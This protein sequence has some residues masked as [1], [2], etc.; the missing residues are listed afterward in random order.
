MKILITGANGQLGRELVDIFKQNYN[1]Y[2]IIPF[3][4]KDL[5]IINYDEVNK[6]LIEIKPNIVINCAAYNKVDDCEENIDYAFK[7]NSI[8]PK[9]IAIITKKINAKI[10][11]FSTDYVFDG[12][13]NI[14]YKEID[15]PLPINIYGKTK[16]LSEEYIKNYNDKHFIF[17]TSWMFS[18]YGN[19][20]VKRIINLSI[21]NNELKVVND[22]IG[23][24]TSARDLAKHVI[25]LV[26]T[27]YYGL[28]HC[29][30][31]G[32]CS[33]Y[34]LAKRTIELMNIN[35]NIIPIDSKCFINKANRP[36]FSVLDNMMLRCTIGDDMNYWG[37]ALE[38]VIREIK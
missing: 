15:Y 4:S 3:T 27:D 6:C 32:Q 14:P 11:H 34:E 38:E 7:V 8:G 30:G 5:N 24:P 35:C 16:V 1:K 31:K 20:F 36:K 9:N 28:Y 22:Q 10:I 2:E 19:N 26:G 29:S 17:R 13:N 12:N 18:K 37:D 33:W 25:K 23:S 21:N